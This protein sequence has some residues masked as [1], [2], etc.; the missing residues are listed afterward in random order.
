[1]V[2]KIKA[3]HKNEIILK[4]DPFAPS[5]PRVMERRGG[6]LGSNSVLIRL[7]DSNKT[8]IILSNNNKFNPDSFGN[9][10][11]LKEA[12]LIKLAESSN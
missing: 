10:A 6:V 8:I 12:L 7:L 11:G 1:M 2:N 9:T 4:A 5:Q 3:K